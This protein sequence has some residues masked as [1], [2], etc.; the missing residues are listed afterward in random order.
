MM[1]AISSDTTSQQ[2]T[3]VTEDVMRALGL[4]TPSKEQLLKMVMAEEAY[5]MSPEYVEECT[6]V[7]SEV[8]GWLR[9]NEELQYRIVS[10]F[11][12][13]DPIE[14]EYAVHALRRATITYPD[15]PKPVYVRNNKARKGELS[16]G[17]KA[18]SVMLYDLD[19][20]PHELHDLC[21]NTK[22][23]IIVGSS[24]T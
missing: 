2:T 16:V 9:I 21:G 1:A 4:K 19:G 17:D 8:N 20:S 7:A 24:H 10:D 18:P 12:F 22:P 14:R 23:T 11:G 5:R 3:A 15:F 6:K 13:T